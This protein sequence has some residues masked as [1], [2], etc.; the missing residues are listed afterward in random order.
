MGAKF[1]YEPHIAPQFEALAHSISERRRRQ[2]T[3]RQG[4][5]PVP[6]PENER[7][8]NAAR[9]N[10]TRQRRVPSD[11]DSEHEA[12][13]IKLEDLVS[14]ESAEWR[15]GQSELRQRRAPGPLEE[16]SAST[17]SLAMPWFTFDF[18]LILAF[19]T[20]LYLHRGRGLLPPLARPHKSFPHHHLGLCPLSNEHSHLSF[21]HP[22]LEQEEHQRCDIPL[23]DRLHPLSH[24][25]GF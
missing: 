8:E 12:L 4:P 21:T 5:V 19:P 1:V 20:L 11:R 9:R 24:L 23:L 15:I 16:V 18:S 7:D 10:T 25:L 14:R 22:L 6:V 17:S 13:N 2:R 3:R